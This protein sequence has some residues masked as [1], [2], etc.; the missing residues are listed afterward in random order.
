MIA[1]A[2]LGIV[3]LGTT[4]VIVSMNHQ[5]Q[6]VNAKMQFNEIFRTAEAAFRNDGSCAANLG[7]V[8][9]DVTFPS[10]PSGGLP[11]TLSQGM[12]LYPSSGTPIDIVGP[13][14]SSPSAIVP[15][16]RLRVESIKINQTGD[17][18][19]QPVLT[20]S[21]A[22]KKEFVGD[23][24]IS[25]SHDF[26][27]MIQFNPVVI[28]GVHFVTTL[29]GKVTACRAGPQ[30]VCMTGSTFVDASGT[31]ISGFETVD[32]SYD[33]TTSPAAAFDNVFIKINAGGRWGLQ[34]HTGEPTG[35]GA[36]F[37]VFNLTGCRGKNINP[38]PLSIDAD[39]QTNN[40]GCTAA[41]SAIRPGASK[42]Y[43]SVCRAL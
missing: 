38:A 40:N 7:S 15:G 37:E 41:I 14:G 30:L 17:M 24:T 39:I 22:Q 16:T 18:A 6:V 11:V 3:S 8:G 25:I 31:F 29:A 34:G 42:L 27:G 9:N 36:K 32:G 35:T 23:V 10:S 12:K 28:P 1:A 43:V 2:I 13:P 33:I 26:Q 5:M 4:S 19:K 20:Y 21:D